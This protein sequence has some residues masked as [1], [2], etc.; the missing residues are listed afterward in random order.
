MPE[1][2]DVEAHK[3]DKYLHLFKVEIK[4]AM[5]GGERKRAALAHAFAQE[6]DLLLLDEPT[7]HL[8]IDGIV[9]LENILLKTPAAI[10][11]T[12]DRAFLDRVDHAHRRARPRA[13]AVVLGEFLGLREDQGGAARRRGGDAAQVR[14]VLGAGRG[15][16]PQGHRGAAHAQRGP[17]AAAGAAA[18][19]SA[20]RAASA[21]AT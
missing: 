16:D 7:N 3:L 12:H 2:S 4:D 13:A 21:S 9:L 1:T 6:P 17:R 15:L 8:D 18:R 10:V 14:Q 19:M 5:S 11:V 20:R